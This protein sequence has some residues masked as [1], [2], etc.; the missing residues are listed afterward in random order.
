VKL[1]FKLLLM[2]AGA[3]LL[4]VVIS[5][6]L[7]PP[8]AD[9]VNR[10]FTTTIQVKDWQGEFHP[11]VVGP[12]NRT[13]VSSGQIPPEM[14]WAVILAEDSNFYK[15]EVLMSRPSRRPSNTI[16]KR[17]ALPGAPPPS[18]SRLPKT[19]ISLERK[20]L[21]ARSWNFIWPGAWNRS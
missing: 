6:S 8:V 4:Y 21:P 11:F 9:L 14:K 19:C 7:L 1:I 3:Y 2:A 12:T 16:W 17:R 15:H 13:W 10:K 18:P 20:P 5:L